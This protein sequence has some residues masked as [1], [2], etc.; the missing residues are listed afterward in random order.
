MPRKIWLCKLLDTPTRNHSRRPSSAFELHSSSNH[1]LAAF[2]LGAGVEQQFDCLIVQNRQAM[3]SMGSSMDWTS[4]DNMD[5]FLFFCAILTG[6]RGVHTPFVQAGAETSDVGTEVVKPEPG[7]SWVGLSGGL[8]AGVVD[9]NAESCRV[10]LP[11]HIPL[12]IHPLRCMY[13]VVVR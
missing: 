11:L 8:V 7:S 1:C 4:E 10:V 3:Q 2:D 9:E 5:D 13:V 12:V 6:R